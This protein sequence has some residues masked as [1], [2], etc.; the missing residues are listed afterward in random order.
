VNILS[1]SI[2]SGAYQYYEV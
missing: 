2:C 1:R